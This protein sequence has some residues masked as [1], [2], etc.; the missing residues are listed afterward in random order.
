LL[1]EI[2]TASYEAYNAWGGNSLYPGGSRPVGLTGTTQGVEVSYDRPY[3][4]QTGAGQFFIREVAMVRFLERYGYP[5]SYTTIDS[6]DRDPGQVDGTRALMDVGHSEYWS[7]AARRA[8]GRARES[9][10]SLL[11]MSSDTMA[12]RV[13]FAPATS[14]SSQAGE[15]DHRIIAYKENAA[16]DPNRSEPT[17]L[18]PLGGADLVGS[19][20]NGC[21]TPRV[22]GPGPPVYRYYSWA[23]AP[24]LRP[25]W[26]FAGTG[27]TTSTR[28]PGIVGYELGQTT[29]ATPPGTQIVGE[30]V[31]HCMTENEPSP[32]HGTVAQTTLYS[33]R[34]GALVFA[35]GTL[36]WMYALEPVPQA[37]P[38]VPGSPDRRVVAMTRNLLDR[39]LGNAR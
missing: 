9:G 10:T 14:A 17:G 21:I 15:A 5:V 34:S 24:G 16:L 6:I 11:F 4:S 19:A 7:E 30:G 12:W 27:V 38:D 18:F 2:P 33:A 23:P 39:V 3:D 35:T 8:L 26:L 28:I 36:G 32:V 31:A 29:P 25:A 20:Y 37:S 13:R 1:A 22:E